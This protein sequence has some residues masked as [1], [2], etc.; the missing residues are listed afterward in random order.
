MTDFLALLD[1]A[2]DNLASPE[3]S[4][5]CRGTGSGEGVTGTLKPLIDN[6]VPVLPVV[7]VKKQEVWEDHA[8][9]SDENS[10]QCRESR[11]RRVSS[12]EREVRE[13]REVARIST[14]VTVPVT[15]ECEPFSRELREVFAAEHA[16]LADTLRQGTVTDGEWSALTRNLLQSASEGDRDAYEERAA[17]IEF[18]AGLPRSEAERR[19]WREVFGHER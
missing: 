7:P 14:S 2:I 11:A 13:L 10:L 15:V 18:D 6:A 17:I 16:A 3:T 12:Q 5:N 9:T 4:R 1:R 8:Q 19:A